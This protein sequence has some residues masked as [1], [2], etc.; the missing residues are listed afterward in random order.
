MKTTCAPSST[1]RASEPLARPATEPFAVRH[2]AAVEP[3]AEQPWLVEQ[4]WFDAGVGILGGH[5][6]VGKT[7]LAA[8]LALAVAAGAP[9]LGCYA[10]PSAGPVLFY[11]AE[12]GACALHRRFEGL[13]AVHGCVLRELPIYLLDTSELRLDRRRDLARLRA[14]IEAVRPR[15]LVLD[16]FVRLVARVDEN[17]AAD[18]SAVLGSLRAIQRDFAVAVLLVHHARKSPAAQPGQALRG[19]GDFAAWSDTN[20]YLA[21]RADKL[22]LQIEHRHAAAPTP[23]AL[24][25]LGEPAP[26][27][28]L[29]DPRAP[30]HSPDPAPDAFASDLLERLST[31]RPQ[32]TVELRGL[33]RRRKTDVVA[34]LAELRTAGLVVHN[35]RGWI[36]CDAD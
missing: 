32:S 28:A 35:G 20:L 17:S 13:A 3:A 30:A 23:L 36:R 1:P 11:G 12:D 19:S 25:L 15:L 5:P 33:V 2:V 31:V 10:A 18:V 4:L 8:E 21:R 22:W 26:H 16:P 34:A 9:A 24:S 29:L 27:L 14:T 7:F 6:K